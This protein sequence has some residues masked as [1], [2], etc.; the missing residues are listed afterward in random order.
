MS[1]EQDYRYDLFISYNRA[2]E[3]WAEQLAARLELEDCRGRKLRVFFAPWD[4]LP[5]EYITESLEEALPQSRKVGL[6]VT[7]EAMRSEWVKIERLVITH[8]A[9]EERGRRLIPLYRRACDKLPALL[10]GVRA[11][12]FEDDAQFEKGYQELLAVIRDEPLRR[13]EPQPAPKNAP[14]PP[15]IPR[16][17]SFGF[18]ARRDERGRDIVERL[19]DEL[20]PGRDQLVTLSGPG[21]IGKTTRAA[22]AARG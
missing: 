9:I 20:A 10:Q 2:D 4:I 7:P 12:N 19:R 13:G 11:I 3:G 1:D 17:P 21:G 8:I 5:G 18:V 14:P 15:P 16:P 6:V 22:E